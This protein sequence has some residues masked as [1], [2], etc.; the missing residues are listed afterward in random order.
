MNSNSRQ[1]LYMISS[2]RDLLLSAIDSKVNDFQQ[3]LLSAKSKWKAKQ[4]R[5]EAV[6]L[7]KLYFALREVN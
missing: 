7:V 2:N 6:K 1:L 4:I 5:A 3:Q